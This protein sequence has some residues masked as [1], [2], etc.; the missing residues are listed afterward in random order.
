M[1]LALP[2]WFEISTFVVLTGIIVFDL[3]LAYR[4]PHIPSTK[5]SALWVGF[6]VLLAL[7]F[8]VLMLVLGDAEHAGQ[9]VA[10]WLTEYSLS[11]DNLFVF[12]IIMAPLLGAAEVQQEVLMVGIL[13]ALV[14]RGIFI[15]LGATAD[16]ELQ[17]DLLHLRRV[18]AL[19]RDPAGLHEQRRRWTRRRA[20]SSVCCASA[21]RSP[22][23][24]TA[25]S[26]APSIDGKKVFTPAARGL[27]RARHDRPGLRARL[28]PRDLRH[29]HRARS[30]C[31]PR[32][33]SR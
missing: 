3:I 2:L 24:S 10:G 9:F 17:L 18:P 27:H 31:S 4:R 15:L 29:H 30:S 25:P 23:P 13:I 11:I 5:E 7:I 8:A 1:E 33:C 22:M 6:Y 32:T 14:L 16:R 26:C 12:V 28:D 19:H 21:C 20:A